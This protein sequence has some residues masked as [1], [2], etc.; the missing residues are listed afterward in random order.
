MADSVRSRKLIIVSSSGIPE[1]ILAGRDQKL[2]IEFYNLRY[3]RVLGTLRKDSE[4]QN[5]EI[6]NL[7]NLRRSEI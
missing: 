3:I 7:R 1:V 2:R 5:F 6:K 4:Q